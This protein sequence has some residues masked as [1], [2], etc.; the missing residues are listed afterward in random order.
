MDRSHNGTF[1]AAGCATNLGLV[2]LG[3]VIRARADMS[4]E[5]V[6][7]PYRD[8]V[9]TRL[10]QPCLLG[11][12][13]ALM[14][15]CVSP[16]ADTL[17]QT[18]AT[19]RFASLAN[20]VKIN[21]SIQEVQTFQ[22]EDPMAN[23]AEDAVEE[24]NRR[25]IWIEVP[26]FGDVFAR[27]VGPTSGPLVL[28]V[29][30]S[31][32]HNSSRFWNE[33]VI[34]FTKHCTAAASN[35]QLGS[36]YQV[37]IDC[38]GYGRSPGDK[39]TIRSYPGDFL[40]NVIRAL[41]RRNAAVIVGSSQGS[42]SAMNAIFQKPHL[43]HMVALVHPVTHS[44]DKFV[45]I[46]QPVLMIYDVDDPGHPAHVGRRLQK[47]V[48]NAQ[49]FEFSSK[50]VGS[51]DA[52]FLPQQLTTM[53]QSYI[54]QNS[55]KRNLTRSM[56]QLSDKCPELIR[57]AGGFR[58]WSERHMGEICPFAYED[59]AGPWQFANEGESNSN[60]DLHFLTLPKRETQQLF[61][62]HDDR[63]DS[64]DEEDRAERLHKAAMEKAHHET[65]QTD[66]DLCGEI[67]V[68]PIRLQACRCGL[69]GCC[70]E[71]WVRYMRDCPVCG[72]VM[73]R[74]KGDIFPCVDCD[75][76]RI[77]VESRLE[78]LA[79]DGDVDGK[80]STQKVAA[81]AQCQAYSRCVHE[82]KCA[83]RI[84][85][86]YGNVTNRRGA[87]CTFDTSVHIVQVENC[88]GLQKAAAIQ[89]VTFNINPS[90]EKPTK[91]LTAPNEKGVFLFSYS[92]GRAFPCVM[93]IYFQAS[94]GLAPLEIDY[95]VQ[96]HSCKKR[97]VLD[98]PASPAKKLSLASKNK[99]YFE[100]SEPP[101]NSWLKYV[102][103]TSAVQMDAKSS[104]SAKE[105]SASSENTKQIKSK[106]SSPIR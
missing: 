83:S 45:N 13:E 58:S 20:T 67:L 92:M 63:S 12:A 101:S 87:K 43:A 36:M 21:P 102:S 89:K 15:A 7:V 103:S 46:K 74:Q 16:V 99:I 42:A 50:K 31:G 66:C 60:S 27:C 86:E 40:E 19:L 57:I 26:G 4:G 24:L 1:D 14:M 17:D 64:E 6:H 91:V 73:K 79:M 51:W 56:G 49:H 9:L 41:G 106:E 76:L 23:D 82:R 88:Q 25:T 37:A 28:Y 77:E 55:S 71:Q 34:D 94:I 81:R 33:V 5:N 68:D 35:G 65:M 29:H 18:I 48:R 100:C 70:A 30:G 3:R 78:R 22:V 11:R 39:Q 90:Y 80:V 85:L 32:P 44:P 75:D 95:V 59:D 62:G 54:H 105:S 97:I 47:C 52:K 38:P 2:V 93:T 10:L 84:V 96:D 69:C 53:L 104:T 98:L 8:S 61:E 72:V